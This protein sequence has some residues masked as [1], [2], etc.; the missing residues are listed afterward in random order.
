MK[1]TGHNRRRRR[2]IVAAC[3]AYSVVLALTLT[4]SA[5]A[6]WTSSGEGAGP[7][8][9]AALETSVLT[10]A[11]GGEAAQ[12]S[13]TAV[14]PPG[15]GSVT[16]FVTRDGGVPAGNC[17]TSAAPKAVTSCTDEGVSLGEHHYTLTAVWR[18]W[19]TTSEEKTVK[20]TFGPATQFGLSAASTAPTAG[21]TDNLTITARD[22]HGTTVTTY[23]GSHNL[24][25]EGA[26]AAPNGT[27]PSV[28]NASG[29]AKRFGEATA[30]EFTAGVASVEATS[31]NGQMTLYRAQEAHI[32][33]KEGSISNGTGL[34]VTVG[35]GA[36]K[37][38]GVEA[39]TP[40]EPAASE[41]FTAQITAWDEWHNTVTSYARAGGKKLIYSGAANSPSGHAPEYSSTT[42][43]T[44]TAGTTEVSGFK[45][46]AAAANTLKVEEETSGHKGEGTVTVKPG[47]F[48]SFGVEA[49]SPAEPAAGEAF[50][51]KITAWDEWHNPV[52]SYARTAGKKL[53]YS[54]AATSPSGHAPEY[55]TTTE[56]TFASGAVEVSGFKFYDA[57]ANTLKVEEETS[58]HKGEGT[59]TIKPGAFKSFAVEPSVSEP[60]A[61]TAFSL[62]LTAWDEWHNTITG[63]VRSAALKYEGAAR[64]PNETAA[65]YG[66]TTPTF[67]NG[68]VTVT[69]FTFY[70]AAS[71]T[72][73]V[74]EETSG[75]E[76][77]KTFTVK[78]AAAEKLAWAGPVAK[79]SGGTTRTPNTGTICLFTCNFTEAGNEIGFSG[80]FKAKASVTDKYGNIVK[81]ENNAETEAE[82]TQTAGKGTLTNKTLPLTHAGTSPAESSL[83]FEYAAP[84][85]AAT[86]AVLHLK[87]KAGTAYAEAGAELKY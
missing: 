36:F 66:S 74:A 40:S 24:T 53:I 21:T 76:G 84:T 8:T 29:T 17:P 77:S 63:Y 23:A 57:I 61:G 85:N 82:V 10:A 73:T 19:R 13:W 38:F 25:F 9:G 44:F 14:T 68:T 46:Y 87:K 81:G 45:L 20:V 64:S 79:T 5:W 50:T 54:G 70:D 7:V 4:V 28:T 55:S 37:S 3:G 18:S 16:Y 32:K 31:H 12:L 62:T 78:A 71:T 86:T 35:I 56:P 51:S 75:H 26:S 30:I 22:V 34:A 80:T 15:S 41:S 43:P 72:L 59:V 83:T 65:A 42:E 33:V 1:R 67:T 60:T 39:K 69:G 48:K 58:G 2:R 47:A 52:T 27:E 6:Y 49:K 11:P